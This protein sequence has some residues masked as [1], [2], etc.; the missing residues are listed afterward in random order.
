MSDNI[1]KFCISLQLSLI[2]I[3]LSEI[4]IHLH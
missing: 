3:L 1:F 2:V 4:L